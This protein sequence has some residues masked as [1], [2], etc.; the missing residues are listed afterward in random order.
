MFRQIR[1]QGHTSRLSLLPWVVLFLGALSVLAGCRPI[2]PVEEGGVPFPA[3]VIETPATPEELTA[4]QAEAAEQPAAPPVGETAADDDPLTVDS[5]ALSLMARMDAA[6]RLL[7]QV[8]TLAGELQLAL[9]PAG[10]ALAEVENNPFVQI[11]PGVRQAPAP[12][13]LR[14]G[15]RVTYYTQNAIFADSADDPA[16]SGAGF[17][18]YD[19]VSLDADAAI[20]SLKYFLAGD[21]SG[22]SPGFVAPS[23]G[24]PGVGDYWIAPQ[25]LARAEE[26]ATPD[27]FVGRMPTEAA[28]QQFNAVRF[29]TSVRGGEYVWMFD[30]VS[31]LLLFHRYRIFDGFGKTSQAGQIML[32]GLRSI[33]LPW[34]AAAVPLWVQPGVGMRFDGAYTVDVGG[35]L[36]P[37][38]YVVDIAIQEVHPGWATYLTTDSLYG[39][40]NSSAVRVNGA[41][42]LH[43]ALW[44]PRAALARLEPGQMLDTDPFTGVSL[45]VAEANRRY[46]TLEETGTL[47]VNRATYDRRNGQLVAVSSQK[48]TGVALVTIELELSSVTTP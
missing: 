25:A 12:D 8:E 5:D 7:P 1:M 32:A 39:R 31:G 36:T 20:T 15:L 9:P 16:P 24:L 43:D 27:L 47:H 11:L 30:E 33:D 19:L 41:A 34:Q 6:R 48:Q 35:S 46:V 4:E 3:Q 29:Q 13:W 26:A 42:Q 28:G 2:Q 23:Y 17:L 18:Q 40:V 37:M 14:P 21:R 45:Q 10:S 38:P 22:Y 44:L